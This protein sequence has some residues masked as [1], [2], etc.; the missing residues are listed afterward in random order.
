MKQTT[1]AV[2]SGRGQTGPASSTEAQL[3]LAD[4]AGTQADRHFS[5]VIVR[6]VVDDGYSIAGRHSRQSRQTGGL[7]EYGADDVGHTPVVVA[8][9]LQAGFEVLTI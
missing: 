7:V 9:L 2:A 1:L 6:A 5:R 3:R 4:Q 8:C